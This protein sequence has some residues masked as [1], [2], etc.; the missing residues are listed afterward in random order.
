MGQSSHGTK[1][2]ITIGSQL[3]CAGREIEAQRG[4]IL[5]RVTQQVRAEP[6]LALNSG[7]SGFRGCKQQKQAQFALNRKGLH[8]QTKGVLRREGNTE[9]EA[10][11]PSEEATRAAE[12]RGTQR[13]PSETGH[14]DEEGVP[15]LREGGHPLERKDRVPA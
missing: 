13:P 12:S 1:A 14:Q 10:E 5:P 4:A 9:G 11:R 7:Q 6:R 15:V 2:D 8:R 3:R